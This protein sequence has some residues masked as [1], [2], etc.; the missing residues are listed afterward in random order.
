[1]NSTIPKPKKHHQRVFRGRHLLQIAVPLGGIGAGCICLNG[2]GGLQD[3]S[4]RHAPANSAE[5]DRHEARDT[6]FALLRLPEEGQT[7]LVE[8]PLPPEKLYDQGLRAQGYNG[9]GQEGLPRFRN[10]SF[11]GEYPFATV[12]L[13]DSA[14]PVDVTITGFNPFIPLDDVNSGIP[15][16]ILEYTLHNRSKKAVAYQF[17]Y[18]LSHL[19]Q[20]GIK[21]SPRSA[22]IPGAGVSFWNEEPAD[23]PAYANELRWC[24]DEIIQQ[25]QIHCPGAK[26]KKINV[27]IA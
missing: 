24:S 6:G 23:S 21:T 3:F 12:K 8:G 1:M 13:S 11:Q 27:T 5:P 14:L 7:R 15:C 22:A 16:A 17:S 2:Y 9:G 20:K 19:A 26:I 25:L 4:I 18:H 10:A